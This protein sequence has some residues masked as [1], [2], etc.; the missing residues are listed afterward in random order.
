MIETERLILRD[1]RD[2][3]REPFAEMSRDPEVMA[4]LGPA[5]TRAESDALVDRLMAMQTRDGFCF[6]ALERK[7]DRAFLGFTGLKVGD[8]API[9]GELEVGWRVVRGAWGGGY[10]TEAA[11]GAV[12]WGF[13]NRPA[14]RI[15][16]ITAV[17]NRR[18]QA[19][20][21]RLGMI[22]RPEL[23]FDHPKVPPGDRLRPHVTY[24]LDRPEA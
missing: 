17:V 19:V 11:R 16:A 13:A 14:P 15:V 23:D 18:S 4:T 24:T 12:A 5:M 10:A 21:E 2:D 3:D 9:E 20:M 1:W 22:R 8:V 7:S 6:W